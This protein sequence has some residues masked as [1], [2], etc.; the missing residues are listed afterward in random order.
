MKT[1]TVTLADLEGVAHADLAA[2]TQVEVTARYTGPVHLADGRIIPPAAKP[3]T[4]GSGSGGAVKFEVY[5]SD[6]PAVKAEYRDF[7]IQVTA[8]ITRTDGRHWLGTFQ[9]TVK[10]LQSAASPVPLG[11]LP[12]AEGLPARWATVSEVT[13]DFDT[14]IDD[15]T[16]QITGSALLPELNLAFGPGT[17]MTNGQ[18]TAHALQ[19]AS[20]VGANRRSSTSRAVARVTWADTWSSV[21]EAP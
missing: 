7:A 16:D 2:R 10:V 8:T 3:K 14:R 15:L 19:A 5:A 17:A 6:D 4:M 9:R 1:L 12:P 18:A 11:S 20:R 21:P 13:G